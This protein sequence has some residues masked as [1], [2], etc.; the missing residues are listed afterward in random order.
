[1]ISHPCRTPPSTTATSAPGEPTQVV[2]QYVWGA[3]PGHRDELILRDRNTTGDGTLD[4]RLYCPMDYFNPVAV[5]DAAGVVKDRL[6]RGRLSGCG[7]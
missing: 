7:R 5:V 6:T 3:R 4:E 1:M 2:A